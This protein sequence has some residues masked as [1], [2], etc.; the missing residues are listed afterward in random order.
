MR[1]SRRVAIAL[2]LAGVACSAVA[3]CSATQASP[4]LGKEDGGAPKDGAPPRPPPP[5]P[6]APSD[7]GTTD[8]AKDPWAAAAD[9]FVGKWRTLPGAPS[10]CDVRVSDEP[11]TLAS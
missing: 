1:R 2:S 3:S 9:V 10:Y 7:A 5:P 8:A 4:D 11:A 6:D